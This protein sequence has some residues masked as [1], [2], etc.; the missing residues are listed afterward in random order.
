MQRAHQGK[1]CAKIFTKVGG[2]EG[3]PGEGGPTGDQSQWK[4]RE[5]RENRSHQEGRKL[6]VT[7]FNERMFLTGKKRRRGETQEKGLKTKT[8]RQKMEP[9]GCEREKRREW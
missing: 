2:P 9:K 6:P 3:S 4:V 8:I 5:A 7:P 1:N